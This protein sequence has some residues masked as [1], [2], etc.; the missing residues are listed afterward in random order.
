MNPLNWHYFRWALGHHLFQHPNSPYDEEEARRISTNHPR[1]SAAASSTSHSTPSVFTAPISAQELES[2]IKKLKPDGSP[3]PSGVTNRII[4]ARGDNFQS[5][6]LILFNIIWESY[7]QPEDWQLSLMKP[8][9]KGHKK[10][11]TDPAS[12]RGIYL[13]D[14]LAKN[15]EGILITRLTF[16]TELHNVLTFN[17]LGTKPSTQTHDAIYALLEI[18]QHNKLVLGKP[19]YVVF[20]EYSTVYPSVHRDKLS[21]ILLDNNIVGNLWNHLRACFNTVTLRVLH[22]GIHEKETV[23]ILR[24]LPEGSRLSPALFGIL[25]AD[26]VRELSMKFPNA[27]ISTSR[28]PP[29]AHTLGTQSQIWIGG[30]LYVD[31]LALIS[32][33][34]RELQEMLHACQLWSIRNRMQINTEKTK[35]MAVFETPATLRSRGG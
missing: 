26:L 19:T 1:V 11:K 32:T 21:S 9:Y 4:Q 23:K 7:T 34:P 24:G 10:E 18:A 8:I 35:M 2:E 25:V 17:Q 31:D 29:L 3:G 13:S 27:S 33:C 15:F 30:L 20:V 22:P 28:H 12:Y 5:Q 16:F 14:T 6:L